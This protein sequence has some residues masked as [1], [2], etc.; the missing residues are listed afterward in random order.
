M[1]NPYAS[2]KN[3]YLSNQVMSASPNKLIEMLIEGSIK[4]IKKAEMAIEDKKIEAA[5]NE[6]VH[7][8]DIVDELKFSV[9]KEIEGDIPQQLIS[10][11]DV[12]EQEL[13]QANIHKDKNH[14]EI[15]LTMLNELLDAW[16]QITK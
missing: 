16:K 14:L 15:A 9:N 13:I 2:H 4:S 10:T 6:I 11:Y 7:A 5:N 3:D 8:Q 12:V 1:A